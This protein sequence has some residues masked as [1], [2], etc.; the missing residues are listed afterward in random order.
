MRIIIRSQAQVNL[1]RM[2]ANIFVFF[3]EFET[4]ARMTFIFW[5]HHTALPSLMIAFI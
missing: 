1:H 2:A 5:M 4:F 3:F